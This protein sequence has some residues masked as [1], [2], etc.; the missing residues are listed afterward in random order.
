MNVKIMIL[1]FCL[2]ASAWSQDTAVQSIY[3]KGVPH[4]D[5]H[6]L[7][8]TKYDSGRSFFQIGIWGN[9]YG[10]HFGYDY[11]LKVLTDAGFNTMWPWY[12]NV[13][14]QLK[15]GKKAGLQVV[16]MGKWPVKVL[17]KVKN[18]PNWLGVV[19]HD[20]PISSFWK[21]DMEGKYKEFLDYKA[22]VNKL[23]PG[24]VIFINDAPWI[25]EPATQWWIKWNTAGDVACHDNYP[26]MDRK[27]RARTLGN[28]T[29]KTG[30]PD[31]MK[32]A[33]AVNKEK[34]PVWL[35]LGAFHA[36]RNKYPFR[37]ATPIQLRA[38][39]YAGIIHGAT[40]IIYFC[41]DSYVCRD[42]GVIGMSPDPQVIYVPPGASKPKPSPAKPMQLVQ[43]KALWVA[44]TQINKE[45]RELTPSLL[46][47][48]V[49]PE[50]KY[51]VTTKGKRVTDKPIRCLLKPHP[52]GGY[53][54]LTVNLDDAVLSTTFEFPDGLKTVAPLFEN[55]KAY[56]IKAKQT[57][58]SDRFEPFDV[59]IYRVT[60]VTEGANN[61][62]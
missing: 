28:E 41:L 53:I 29:S 55:R 9:P 44:S 5:K 51:T 1:M 43:S 33:V 35:I 39:V 38:Q 46:S 58:F 22:K 6:G 52:D 32:L 30:I 3:R 50:V 34:K 49:G 31:S 24:R 56:E 14:K 4:T 57:N 23:S 61:S 15:A 10:K 8:L 42:G 19:W 45:L 27:H 40:G 16:I 13:E 21:K 36:M 54:L 26:L 18:H 17:E 7:V 62:N 59:H 11:D 48:T 12:S 25:T 47:S 37:M 2:S 60:T 20:E